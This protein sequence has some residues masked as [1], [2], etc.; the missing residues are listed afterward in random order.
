MAGRIKSLEYLGFGSHGMSGCFF[1]ETQI[2]EVFFHLKSKTGMCFFVVLSWEE[3][4]IYI[5]IP[6]VVLF[7]FCL[8]EL[9]FCLLCFPDKDHTLKHLGSVAVWI[10]TV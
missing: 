8:S 5:H 4:Y 6:K 10:S 7:F 2:D 1:F 9:L 3:R